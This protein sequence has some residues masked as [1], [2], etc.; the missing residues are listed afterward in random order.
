MNRSEAVLCWSGG[1]D[2]ALALHKA[3]ETYDIKTL[4]TTVSREFKRISMHGVREEL[5]NDQAK[6]IG[7]PLKIVY[8]DSYANNAD[9]QAAMDAT[10]KPFAA[11]GITNV[12]FGDI[13]L[14]DLRRW[15]EKTLSDIGMIGQFPLW[16]EDTTKLARK[17]IDLGYKATVCCVSSS[18]LIEEK[19]GV[20]YDRAFLD[21]LPEGVDLCGERGE[22]HTFVQAGPIFKQPMKVEIGE[23]VF[24][25]ALKKGE[26]CLG[27]DCSTELPKGFWF[28]DLLRPAESL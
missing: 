4:I 20:H 19:V 1:K 22:F 16:K 11:E 23:T 17:F 3:R 8:L 25:P 9:Y 15:R 2:S 12:I 5:L 14:E 21:S 28:C 7:L 26:C 10:L 13:F 6:A 24:K 18:Y 27:S